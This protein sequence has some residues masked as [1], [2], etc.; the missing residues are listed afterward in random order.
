[1]LYGGKYRKRQPLI[2]GAVLALVAALLDVFLAFS[3]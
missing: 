1:M 3:R 2:V